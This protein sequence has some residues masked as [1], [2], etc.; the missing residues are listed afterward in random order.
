MKKVLFLILAVFILTLS[1]PVSAKKHEH[2]N[3]SHSTYHNKNWHQADYESLP[4]RWH[5]QRNYH[6]SQPDYR[7]E[8]VHDREWQARFPGLHSYRWHDT[9]NDGFWYHGHRIT[10]AVFFYDDGDE[11]VSIGFMHEGV[12]IF[13]RDDNDSYEDHDSFFISWWHR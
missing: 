13:I 6:F 10:D 12:F 11:L 9:R 2:P 4:F 3:W 5:E 1:S 7:L 8:R